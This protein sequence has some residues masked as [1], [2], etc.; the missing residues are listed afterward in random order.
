MTP[1]SRWMRR[2]AWASFAAA[3][4][5]IALMV[6]I[7]SGFVENR[8][9]R[10]VVHQ[11]GRRTG[12]RAELRAFHLHI[13]QL[14]AELDDLTVHGLEP[15]NVAPLFRASRIRVDLRLV[16]FFGP[17][18]ALDELVIDEPQVRV[19]VDAAGQSNLPSPKAP[20][21]SRP[22][23]DTLF[24][25]RIGRLELRDGSALINDR[26]VPLSLTG[27]DLS[28]QLL[29]VPPSAGASSAA[30]AGHL[31]W[32]QV[33]LAEGHAMPFPFDIDTK[34]TLHRDSFELDNLDWKL[35]HSELNLRAELQSFGHPD[36][37]FHY[38][39]RLSLVDVRNIFR[40]PK[41]PDA[42][43]DFSGQ[44]RY[45]QGE[46]TGSGHYSG[47]NIRLPYEWFHAAGMEAWGDYEIAHR[48]L[49]VP[50][51]GVRALE[52]SLDG[53]LEMNFDKLSF[54]TE[55]RLRGADLAAVFHALEN[56]NF[57]VESLHWD[58][59]LDVDS[60]NTWQ[61]AFQHFRSKGECRWT[62]PAAPAAGRIPMSARIE[63]DY[64]QDRRG[65]LLEPSQI[66]DPRTQLEIEG[67]LGAEDSD[68]RV[69]FHTDDL[70]DWDDFI[71]TLRGKDSEPQRITG[72]V[73]WRG[74]LMG[75]IAGPAFIGH[76]HAADAHYGRLHWDELDGDMEYSP[77]EFRL[78][79]ASLRI[80]QTNATL[81]LT[82]QFDDWSYTPT[83]AFKFETN[84][85]RTPAADIQN[86]LGTSYPVTGFLSGDFR[87]SGTRSAP[88]FDS[89]FI[90][91]EIDAKAFRLDRFTGHLHL[92][93][94]EIRFT[95]AE[96]RRG[97]GRIAGDLLYRPAEQTAEYK[98]SGS[99]IPLDDLGLFQ[100]GSVPLT[101]QVG[102]HVEASGP[103]LAPAGHGEIRLVNLK[104]GAEVEGNVV[105]E[106]TSDGQS[107]H[108]ALASLLSVGKLEGQVVLGLS[109]D[110]PISGRLAVEQVD[111]DAFIMSGLHLK[112]LTGHSSVDGVFTVSGALRQPD[113][114][115]ID[116]D[117]A[118]ISFDY[119][120]V[121]LHNDGP[122][123]LAYR[124]NEVRIEQ[125]HLS[126]PNTDLQ[127]AGSARF[128]RDRPLHLTLSGGAN[129]RLLAGFVPHLE[130]NGRADLNVALE[131][132]MS[133]P[134]VTGRVRI[135][136]AAATYADF[137]VGLSH[138][139]GDLAFDRSRLLFD[140]VTAEAGGGQLI[141]SG[142]VTYGEEEL[143][144]EITAAT[145]GVRIRYPAGMS[146]LASGSIQLS[147]TSTS[148]L[149]TGRVEVKRLLLAQGVDVASFFAAA[150]QTASA[151]TTTSPFLRNLAFDVEG[152][153]TPGARIEWTGAE[154]DIDGNVRL[155]GTWD[156]PVLLGHIHLLGGQMAFRGNTFTLTRG[157]INFA[158]PFQLDPELNVEAT[159]T[160]SQYQVTI[161]FSGRA[162]KLALNYRSDP[163]L[164]DSDI[165]SLL[166]LGSTGE[167]SALRSSS[168]G[169]QNYGATALLSEAISSG[170]G[171]RIER[172]FGISHFRVDPF[173]AGTATEANAA[174]RITVEQQVTHDLTITYS[175]NAS[176]TNQYQLIQ[177]EYAVKRDLS[178]VF[179]RDIN[180]T[181]GFDVKFV[182]HFK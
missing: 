61:G 86:L 142:N 62:P 11:I 53:R 149:L 130:A 87:G 80:G 17:K 172:L 33:Q 167:E 9:G 50:K 182:R 90:F 115:E 93:H 94:D 45:L 22:W 18:F 104:S 97:N 170:L 20:T 163:P 43:T 65:V 102:F 105:A 27:R 116:A 119:E 140:H 19:Q 160:I 57:P 121:Q 82:L 144:Y 174:A 84:V 99:G 6:A 58:S 14:R 69:N 79:G 132:T 74:R 156:R 162:S 159:A 29:Y 155:R 15:A 30:Y 85:Q 148:G 44:A 101:A 153:T 133:R 106:I 8:I 127:L 49:I 88:V 137:P 67:S 31:E 139:T 122:I 146:W 60:V 117:I 108:F 179:L 168:A 95:G 150:S 51:L 157:D 107:A 42:I 52:A 16:S 110:H 4:L 64:A 136:D 145:S 128:D 2:L 126:G 75:P 35:P 48:Q 91:E 54:R 47:H 1:R 13:W 83:S 37:N 71:N 135:R 177:V 176:T 131:G 46:W 41:T 3:A 92:A 164:P 173:L 36:W 178:V 158:N 68:L 32:K 169:S 161:T 118:R 73:N 103:L 39:G 125:A 152:Q 12:G 59:R 141:L 26:R 81:N 123:R 72:N 134:R 114:I 147:G 165:V 21:A 111:M 129:L 175:S 66:S 5:V 56:K 151:P 109:G 100:K 38:R 171:G 143:R 10:L 96:I 180:G 124:R 77:D 166:A 138:V 25:L 63:Y 70:L 78:T 34:F 40:A 112:Q 7:G 98:L 23:R 24:D 181:Y 55:T 89:N 113:Q 120:L 28:F 76:M 154:L